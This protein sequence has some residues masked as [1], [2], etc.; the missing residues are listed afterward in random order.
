MLE[1][2]ERC[3]MRHIR[4]GTRWSERPLAQR[5]AQRAAPAKRRVRERR[6]QAAERIADR[7]DSVSVACGLVVLDRLYHVWMMADDESG[8]NLGDALRDGELRW[9]WI[10]LVFHAPM[11]LCDDE[12]HGL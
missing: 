1:Q 9:A 11:E 8:T 7:H 5:D 3:R 6:D 4:A 10:V 2:I 12:V